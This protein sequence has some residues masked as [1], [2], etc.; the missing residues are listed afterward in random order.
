MIPASCAIVSTS[1]FLMAFA[2]TS[3]YAS[4]PSSTCPEA[5]ARRWVLPFCRGGHTSVQA[6]HQ[7]LHVFSGAP[8]EGKQKIT[9]L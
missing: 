7:K 8:W 6:R 3:L 2:D 1:P 5:T 9:L 4:S